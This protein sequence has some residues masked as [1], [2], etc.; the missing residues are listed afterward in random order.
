MAHAT[1]SLAKRGLALEELSLQL[2]AEEGHPHEDLLAALRPP[3]HQ[4]FA[5]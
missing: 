2:S 4:G 1:P 3:S 5:R